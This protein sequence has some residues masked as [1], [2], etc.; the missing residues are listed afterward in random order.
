MLESNLDRSGKS[1]HAPQLQTVAQQSAVSGH[2][3][4]LAD[5]GDEAAYCSAWLSLQCASITGVSLGVVVI[6]QPDEI[7]AA[8]L[9]TWP[10]AHLDGLVKLSK[11]AECA[12]QERRT[13]VSAEGPPRPTTSHLIAVPLGAG[14]RIIAAAAVKLDAL[15]G[16]AHVE[17]VVDQLRWGA[18]WLESLPLARLLEA[19][20]EEVAQALAC[21]DVLAA[22]QQQPR[23]RGMTITIANHLATRLGCD[24]VSVGLSRRSGRPRLSA[25]SHSANF[26]KEGRLVDAIESAMEEAMDQGVSLTYPTSPLSERAVTVAHRVLGEVIRAPNPALMSVPLP[27]SQGKLIGAITFERHAGAAFDKETLQLAEA[28]AALLGPSLRL[29]VRANRPIAGRFVDS[30]GEFLRALLGAGRPALKLGAVCVIGLVLALAFTKAEHRISARAVVEAEVQRAAVAPFEGFIRAAPVRAGDKVKSGDLLAALD[31]RD[32]LLDQS[33]WRAE[34]DKLLQR[35]RDALAN[36]KRVDLVVLEFQIRQAKSQL[37]LAE[38]NLAR[39]RINAPFDGTVVAGDLSQLLGS[40]VEKGKTLFEIAPLNAYRLMLHVD[41]RD[42]RYIAA[43]Q[44]GSVVLAG[45]PWNSL[46]FVLSK[47]TPV[48]IVAEGQNT[49]S[50]EGRLT[51]NGPR[52]RPGMEGV[53]KIETGQRPVLWIWTRSVVEWMRLTAWMYLP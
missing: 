23:L 42:M 21:L 27:D 11:L 43:G 53:A 41:E 28:I 13:I 10:A 5:A 32:L 22:A 33:K 2:W 34:R 47:I 35:Q 49:F 29:Q 39:A 51:E 24:R 17:R 7:S 36:H 4:D 19:S 26:K 3:N 18:G 1:H 46:P 15:A 9:A 12:L 38:D 6:R 37:S 50:V 25:I 45:M 44:K 30:T 20:S 16:S 40:P 31:D 8:V 52:L 14:G 48:T